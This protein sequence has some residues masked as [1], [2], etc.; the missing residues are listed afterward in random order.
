[1]KK[2]AC[3]LGEALNLNQFMDIVRFGAEVEFSGDY[4]K[5]VEKSR[6]IVEQWIK[7]EKVMY[8]ITTGFGAL[9]THVISK[10]ETA[11]LQENIILSHATSVGQPFNEEEARAVM[12]MI[13]QNLGQ[14]YSGVRML[15]LEQYRDFLNKGIIPY[16]PKEGS[17]GYLSPEAHMALVL[18]GQ[19]KAYYK[20]QLMSGAEALKLAN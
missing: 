13:L 17:V 12:L 15:V 9:C 16:A 6:E 3:V 7:D 14:G 4:I 20:G 11:Q 18:I 19:G 8:G 1:M 5:R 2:T 10:E